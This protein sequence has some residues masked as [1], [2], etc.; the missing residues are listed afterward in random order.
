MVVSSWAPVQQTKQ[1]TLNTE[2]T[3]RTNQITLHIGMNKDQNVVH[4]CCPSITTASLVPGDHIYVS[5]GMFSGTKHGVYVGY[6]GFTH[7]I[8]HIK[9]HCVVQ[10]GLDQFLEGGELKR[11]RYAVSLMQAT[12]TRIIPE[13]FYGS[14]NKGDVD[15]CICYT[16]EPND[17]HTIVS[18]ALSAVDDRDDHHEW[19]SDG[20]HFAKYCRTGRIDA[21][22]GS[23]E[24]HTHQ[25]HSNAHSISTPSARTKRAFAGTALGAGIGFVVAGPVGGLIGGAIG[26]IGPMVV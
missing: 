24:L 13:S 5:L 16:D 10:S 17:I 15:G 25:A 8:V 6:Q 9:D 20:E 3:S 22:T 19:R 18:R 26:G 2:P 14:N 21:I 7:W 4:D 23:H 11:A 12:M 1:R